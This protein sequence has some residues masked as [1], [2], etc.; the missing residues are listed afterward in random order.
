MTTAKGFAMTVSRRHLIDA[1]TTPFYHIICRCVRRAFL[2]GQDELTG[3]DFSHRRYWIE[4]KLKELTEV[5][6]VDLAA[7]A[8]MNNHYHLVL[9]INQKLA[10]SWSL[11]E[12]FEK[13]N[14]LFSSI[15]L[16]QRYMDKI[17]LS[18][19]E[20]YAVENI[21]KEYRQR[22]MSISWFMRS[23]NEFVARKANKEDN[24]KGRFW[25][26]RFKSQ[27]LLD[28]AALLTCMA[29]VDLN[30]VRANIV[31][32]PESSD[33]T[34]IQKR[35]NKDTQIKLMPFSNQ[36]QNYEKQGIPFL[37]IDYID[38]VDW[39]GRCIRDDKRGA[40]PNHLPPILE[41][42]Q[43]D[44]HKWLRHTLYFEARFKRVAGTLDTIKK[45]TKKLGRKW[46]HHKQPKNINKL[47]I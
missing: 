7:Y 1:D 35:I 44:E 5:F 20:L 39:T 34:S 15:P 46:F 40:I 47:S 8:I 33:F 22:L 43:I 12:V 4:D 13:Y 26:S 16:V 6:A 21:G 37:E 24:C 27:A 11:N 30:P 19:A 3:R 18:Q 2:C 36:N 28:E 25:E 17:P 31:K 9:H 42:I 41:R 23:I 29:Y 45:V 38:L 14:T 10:Q 32:T